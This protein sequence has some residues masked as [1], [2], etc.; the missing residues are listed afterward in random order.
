MVLKVEARLSGAEGAGGR[1]STISLD[2]RGRVRREVC[3]NS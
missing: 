2:E 3:V 1:M